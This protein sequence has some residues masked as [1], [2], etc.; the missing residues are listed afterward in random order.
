VFLLEAWTE[1]K[2]GG[3]GAVG[4]ADAGVPF[5]R[6]R[7]GAGRPCIGEE[8]AVKVVRHNGNEGGRF[9]RGSTGE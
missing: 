9:R 1:G 7:G 6:V 5:Y 4:G 8:Q 3:G 2:E